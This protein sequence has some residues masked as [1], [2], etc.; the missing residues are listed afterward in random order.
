MLSLGAHGLYSDNI[1]Q[2]STIWKVEGARFLVDE[3]PCDW[4]R[5][6]V[7]G[8]W[9]NPIQRTTEAVVV[10]NCVPLNVEKHERHQSGEDRLSGIQESTKFLEQF[11][12]GKS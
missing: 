12:K 9:N 2:L 11:I 7:I 5:E 3:F 4:Q 10:H 8:F 1:G 6:P